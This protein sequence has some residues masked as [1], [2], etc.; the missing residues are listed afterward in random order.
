MTEYSDD[1]T[2]SSSESESDC[3]QIE[4]VIKKV[5]KAVPEVKAKR[6]YT[7]NAPVTDESKK[8]LTDKLQKAREAKAA[9]A[10]EKKQADA[11]EVAELAEIK[12]LKDKGQL[13]VKKSK[14]TEISIPR[15]K[16]EKVVVKEIH[17]YHN[18]E[19]AAAP[20]PAPPKTPRQP[21]PP[22]PPAM[23]FA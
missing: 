11:Q 23:I 15:K 7:K 21:K 5:P 8:K 19:P 22:K 14:P 20:A 10:L 17:H 6:V 3:E 2:V 13:R 16:R 1:E 12:K 18:S 9:K 4:A